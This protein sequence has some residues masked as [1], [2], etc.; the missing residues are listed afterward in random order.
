RDKLDRNWFDNSRQ[1]GLAARQYAI[2][3][4][5]RIKGLG[6]NSWGMSASISPST[7]YS[8]LYGSYPIGVGHK[9][10]EDGT[11]APYGALSFL[12]FTPPESKAALEHMYKIPGLVGKYGLYDAYSYATKAKGDQ[13]WIAKSYLVIDKGLVLLMFENYSTQLIWRLLHQNAHIQKGLQV[14]QFKQKAFK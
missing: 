5:L 7:G 13:P 2:D 4:A 8:G 1:A 11:V 9:L 10:L 3:N 12:P 6:P 14:L